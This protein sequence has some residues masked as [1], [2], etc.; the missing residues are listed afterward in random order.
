MQLCKNAGDEIA[1]LFDDENAF[2]AQGLMGSLKC[3]GVFFQRVGDTGRIDHAGD[4]G[5]A[6]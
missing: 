1:A 2:L 5:A 6:L 4:P 3:L